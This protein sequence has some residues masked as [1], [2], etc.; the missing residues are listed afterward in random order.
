MAYTTYREMDYIYIC[1][2]IQDL[3]SIE[4]DDTS[5]GCLAKVIE[6]KSIYILNNNKEWKLWETISSTSSGGSS[7]DGTDNGGGKVEL[8]YN[9]NEIVK[10]DEPINFS[11]LVALLK[12]SQKFVYMLYGE[13]A[14]LPTLIKD[15]GDGLKYIYFES[16]MVD[17]YH[18]KNA[19]IQ[20]N[21]NDGLS[22][23][24]IQEKS[25][26][27]ENANHKIDEIN[28]S[29][30]QSIDNYPSVNAVTQYAKSIEDKYVETNVGGVATDVYYTNTSYSNYNLNFF[31]GYISDDSDDF[32]S[33]LALSIKGNAPYG[34]EKEI[35][36]RS[37]KFSV[38]EKVDGKYTKYRNDAS[39]YDEMQ[40]LSI[41]IT[42]SYEDGKIYA[43][44]ENLYDDEDWINVTE[45]NGIS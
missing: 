32:N 8:V 22:I 37:S 45:I 28:E 40:Y 29:N 12:L 7:S 14:Y 24:G 38:V 30:A 20:I 23:V 18:S 27:N 16:T 31:N 13:R 42:V 36:T 17:D 35:I 25:T 39:N 9:G 34:S 21:S 3:N 26:V 41:T 2:T 33:N 11:G 5:I 4:T 1:D 6:N 43:D 44:G 10:D 19:V 15:S